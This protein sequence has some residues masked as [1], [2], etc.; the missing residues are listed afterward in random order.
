MNTQFLIQDKAE[1]YQRNADNMQCVV[2]FLIQETYSTIS[3]LM[4][5]LNYQ[6]RQ[7]LDRL[8]AKLK[9]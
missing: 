2:Q 4:V 8:L 3:N 9:G 6:K 7:P 1:R 5:L